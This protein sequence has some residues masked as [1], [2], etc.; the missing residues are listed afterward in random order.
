MKPE[1]PIPPPL[2]IVHVLRAPVGGLF[3]H[4]LDLTREQAARGHAVGVIADS[5][6]GGARGDALLAELEPKLALGLMRL[7]IQRGPSL[8]DIPA[9][10]K[11][12]RRL[13]ALKPDVIHGHG[14]KGGLFARL[15]GLPWPSAPAMRAYTP[16]G[17]SLNYLPGT[18]RHQAYMWIEALLARRTNLLLF[19]SAF[20][21]SRFAAEVGRPRGVAKI[22]HNGVAASELSPVAAAAD[23]ADFLYVGEFRSVKGLDTLLDALSLLAKDGRRPRLAMVGDGPDKAA[24][25]ARASALS[26][27]EQLTMKAPMG[28]RDAFAQGRIMVVPSRLESLPYIVLEA[29]AARKPLVATRV[30]GVPEIFGPYADRLIACDDPQALADAMRGELDADPVKADAEAAQLAEHVAANFSLQNMVD[31]IIAGYRQA[32]AQREPARSCR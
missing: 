32:L 30:G 1:A 10:A 23:A 8:E 5:L 2:R 11:I 26:V 28:V 24:L 22:V 18:R 9:L 29:A 4:V 17:G 14:S 13:A 25:L 12:S 15:A 7:P 3:R 31:A 6:T 27:A 20:I 21:A 16:H 19:E